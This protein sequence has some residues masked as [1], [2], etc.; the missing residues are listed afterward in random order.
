MG[1]DN[2][3]NVVLQVVVQNLWEGCSEIDNGGV[4]VNKISSIRGMEVSPSKIKKL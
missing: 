1:I 3:F 4:S 2:V